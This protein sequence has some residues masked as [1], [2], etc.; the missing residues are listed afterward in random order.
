MMHRSPTAQAAFVI[1]TFVACWVHIPITGA[2]A[3][4]S[5]AIYM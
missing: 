3:L 5:R 4:T 1:Y 2:H